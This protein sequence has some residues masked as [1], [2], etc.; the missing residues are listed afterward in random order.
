MCD[1]SGSFSFRSVSLNNAAVQSGGKISGCQIESIDH[2]QVELRQFRE[3][4]A[5]VDGIDVGGVWKGGRH[6]TI[7]GTYYGTSRA[8]AFAGI[9]ALDAVMLPES[10]TFGYYPL[11]LSE[12]TL[13][14]M[15]QGLRVV[16]QRRMFGGNAA[17][18]LAIPWSVSFYAKN[19]NFA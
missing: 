1:L 18:A 15:P 14:V 10:G 19:P 3:P 9:A 13:Q 11:V 2:S 17:D 8:A 12:G 6:V 5:M 16:W 4:L 7:V